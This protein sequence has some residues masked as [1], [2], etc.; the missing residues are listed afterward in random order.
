MNKIV[1]YI[2]LDVHKETL[3]VLIAP[4]NSSELRRYGIIGGV[5][6]GE[7][8]PRHKIEA[9]LILNV[10]NSRLDG[11]IVQPTHVSRPNAPV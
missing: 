5:T 9:A 3:A 10:Q 8:K 6:L 4:Q 2:G 11:S 7:G 1:H